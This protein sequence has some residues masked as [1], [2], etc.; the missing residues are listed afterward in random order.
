MSVANHIQEIKG[1]IAETK[2]TLSSSNRRKNMAAAGK[3]RSICTA[4]E[5]IYKSS[6]NADEI[7]KCVLWKA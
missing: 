6:P 1:K 5:N 4:L 2:K 7:T 3:I